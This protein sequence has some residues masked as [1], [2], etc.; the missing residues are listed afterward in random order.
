MSNKK[1][2]AKKETKDIKKKLTRRQL[3]M[4][5]GSKL[6]RIATQEATLNEVIKGHQ[7]T[8]NA[9]SQKKRGMLEAFDL[10]TDSD[11]QFDEKTFEVRY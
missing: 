8:L 1:K 2:K 9:L 11:I 4:D 6:L 10:P 3:N 7:L 5:K